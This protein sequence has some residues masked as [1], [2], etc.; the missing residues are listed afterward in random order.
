MILRQKALTH[1]LE[2]LLGGCHWLAQAS[3]GAVVLPF[4]ADAVV[5]GAAVVVGAMSVQQRITFLE[6]I[7]HH[8]Y[9]QQGQSLRCLSCPASPCR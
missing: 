3:T 2:M 7:A 9:S 4:P 1:D 5:E 6:R 8:T